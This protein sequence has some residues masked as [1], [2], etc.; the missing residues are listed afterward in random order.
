M[1][2]IAFPAYGTVMTREF[3]ETPAQNVHRTE[4]EAGYAKQARRSSTNLV[5]M[6][7]KY[8]FTNAEYLTFKTWYYDTADAGSLFFDWESPV[9]D[10]TRDTRIVNGTM[11]GIPVNAHFSHWYVSMTFEHYQ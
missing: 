10:V 7:I 6:S 5:Q 2:T 11:T 4:M 9:D 1:A 8:L 3:S